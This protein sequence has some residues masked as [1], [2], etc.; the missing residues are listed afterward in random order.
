MTCRPS[1]NQDSG[2]ELP[3]PWATAEPN[4]PGLSSTSS[5]AAKLWR[6]RLDLPTS[7]LLS[8][9]LFSVHWLTLLFKR[10][11]FPHIKVRIGLL[12]F[13]LNCTNIKMDN[14]KYDAPK[15]VFSFAQTMC[16]LGVDKAPEGV[17]LYAYKSHFY[18]VLRIRIRDPVFFWS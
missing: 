13:L 6:T 5:V 14:R 2:Q 10:L 16:S 4:R 11:L 1:G 18:S 17:Q 3:G 9:Q 8:F 7:W 15:L 12:V